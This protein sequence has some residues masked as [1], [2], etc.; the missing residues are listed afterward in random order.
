MTKFSHELRAKVIKESI[1]GKSIRML[2][3]EFSVGKTTV[4]TG[5]VKTFA[6]FQF[7]PLGISFLNQ[8]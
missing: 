8:Q 6:H 4:G 2:A 7:L 1:A 3:K 5:R